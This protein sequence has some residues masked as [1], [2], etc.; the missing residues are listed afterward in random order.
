MWAWTASESGRCPDSLTAPIEVSVDA[1]AVPSITLPDSAKVLTP[2]YKLSAGEDVWVS[3]ESPFILAFPV[4]AGAAAQNLVLGVAV[5]TDGIEDWDEPGVDMW[6]M[7]EGLYHPGKKLFLTTIPFLSADGQT[8]VLLEDPGYES[9]ETGALGSSGKVSKFDARC[10]GWYTDVCSSSEIEE[11]MEQLLLVA[12]TQLIAKGFPEPHMQNLAGDLDFSPN[13]LASLGH[14]AYI[15][16]LGGRC[17]ALKAGGYYDSNTGHVAICPQEPELGF[18]TPEIDGV[19]HEYFHAVQYGFKAV[20]ADG[21]KEKW[22]IEGMATAAQRSY[23][24]SEMKRSD[25]ASWI[26]LHEVDEELRSKDGDNEYF[27]QDFWIYGGRAF[28]E[29]LDYFIPL[30]NA[31]AN[32]DAIKPVLANVINPLDELYWRWAKNQFMEK[33]VNF[34]NDALGQKCKL[35]KPIVKEKKIWM[36]FDGNYE[37]TIGPLDSEVVEFRW[38]SDSVAK[39]IR[40]WEVE[41]MA[42]GLWSEL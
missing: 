12:H 21:K 32:L 1:A 4:P 28:G 7:L 14:L 24:T 33:D 23:N 30:L 26:Q 31:G 6:Q 13:L 27:T 2:Y 5:A 19:I 16:P 40:V 17:K 11:E 15:E 35:D 34:N 22:I 39:L 36:A 8:F 25:E 3:T 18:T 20:L 9:P 10:R 41:S 38:N 42:A 37:G 29:G